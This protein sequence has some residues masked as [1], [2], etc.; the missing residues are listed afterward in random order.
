MFLLLLYK[1][2]G[3]QFAWGEFSG[4]KTP[5]TV[6]EDADKNLGDGVGPIQTGFS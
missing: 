6:E 1:Y 2:L 3:A 5:S 4:G